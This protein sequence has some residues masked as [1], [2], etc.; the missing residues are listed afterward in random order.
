M[1]KLI[2]VEVQNQNHTGK[3]F[4]IFNGIIR[5]STIDLSLRWLKSVCELNANVKLQIDMLKELS[6][7]L[8]PTPHHCTEFRI[9]DPSILLST[10]RRYEHA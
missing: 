7:M 9:V 5:L 1:H 2:E 8:R 4:P 3:C 10:N 6:L